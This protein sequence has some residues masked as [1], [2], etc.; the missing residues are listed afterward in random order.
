MIT[1][2]EIFPMSAATFFP[3][4]VNFAV[5]FKVTRHHNMLITYAMRSIHSRNDHLRYEC[6]VKAKTKNLTKTYL[7]VDYKLIP[8]TRIRT[9]TVVGVWV[10]VWFLYISFLSWTLGGRRSI[11]TSGAQ[12]SRDRWIVFVRMVMVCYPHYDWLAVEVCMA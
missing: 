11:F 5:C 4:C 10:C 8:V 1:C 12:G 2:A 6:R 3:W 9:W 7:F